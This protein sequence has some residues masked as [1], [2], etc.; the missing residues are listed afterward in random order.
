MGLVLFGLLY[1]PIDTF[2][3]VLLTLQS[4]ADERE[5]DRYSVETNG[6]EEALVSGLKNLSKNNLDNLTPHPFHVWLNYSHPPVLERVGL[7]RSYAAQRK[8]QGKTKLMM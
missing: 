8:A 4:R 6:D 3:E 1:A 7:I 5:A 2:L